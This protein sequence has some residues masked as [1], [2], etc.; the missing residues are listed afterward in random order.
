MNLAY[1]EIVGADDQTRAGLFGTTAQ[2][3]G[4]TP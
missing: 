2:R 4:T 1:D 3:I